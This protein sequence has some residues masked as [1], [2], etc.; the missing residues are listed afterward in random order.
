M[1]GAPRGRTYQTCRDT[2]QCSTEPSQF[3][4][5]AISQIPET[6]H[7]T[8]CHCDMYD[9]VVEISLALIHTSS[10]FIQSI[11]Y[12]TLAFPYSQ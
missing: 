7:R 3:M 2:V 12:I 8:Y 11:S 9:N 10:G 4:S 5:T 6:V 1:C